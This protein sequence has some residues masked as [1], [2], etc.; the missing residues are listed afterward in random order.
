MPAL[1][2]LRDFNI[3][4]AS[5]QLWIFKGPTGPASEDPNYTGRWADTTDGVDEV[6]KEVFQSEVGRIE[7][8]QEY[9]L[10]A[11]NNE[12]SALRITTNET[13]AG[14]VVDEA[15]AEIDTKKASQV[16]HLRNAKFYVAKFVHDDQV[17]HAVRKTD[18][19]WRTKKARSV[20]TLLFSDDQLG[21]D[22]RPRF[23]IAKTFD[24]IIIGD[25]ILCLNKRNFESVLRYKEAHKG[26][27]AALQAEQD[28]MDVFVDI[29]PLV[30]HVGENKI[31]LRRASAIREKGH[32]RD[33]DFMKRLRD[34]QAEFGLEIQFNGD[35]K[36][37]ATAETCSQI[38]TALL[39][40]RL[41]SAF[42]RLVYDVPSSTPVAV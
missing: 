31:Q 13:H 3:A 36:I 15:A 40:H 39:D 21:I 17:V 38:M 12:S 16:R 23:D 19:N 28:F 1:D 22:N 18:S 10:L 24:F 7:E 2:D 42:S 25:Q 37:I 14:Y 4:D 34:N 30:E 5:A 20:Q 41:S 33:P 26:D 11:E 6:L 27:F 9:G 32:Y 8:V 29:A 35:G